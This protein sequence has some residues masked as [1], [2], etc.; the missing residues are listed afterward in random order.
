VD[1]SLAEAGAWLAKGV[2]Q[3]QVQTGLTLELEVAK[4]SIEDETTAENKRK[5]IIRLI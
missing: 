3:A 1:E 2:E 4:I 5:D